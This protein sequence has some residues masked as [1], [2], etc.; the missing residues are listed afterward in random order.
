MTRR[1]QILLN[2]QHGTDASTFAEFQFGTDASSQGNAL[3]QRTFEITDN[4]TVPIGTHSLT[5]GTKNVFYKSINLFAQNRLGA[6]NFANLTS[7]ENGGHWVDD[8]IRAHV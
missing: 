7:L 6:W 4:F 1:L 2:R 8:S 3:D 5:L